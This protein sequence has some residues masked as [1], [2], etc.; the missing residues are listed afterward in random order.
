[1]YNR[2]PRTH[3]HAERVRD[4]ALTLARA[5]GMKDSRV[6]DAIAGSALVHDVGKLGIADDIL[7]KPAPLT[8]DEYEQVKRHVVIGS[9]LLSAAL[10]P[11]EL[12]LIVRHHHERWDGTGYPNRLPGEA[13]PIGARIVT[14]AD[15]FDA[16][17]SWRPY[18]SAYTRDAAVAWVTQRRGTAFDPTV[19]DA[20]MRTLHTIADVTPIS[21]RAHM[22]LV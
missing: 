17:T 14:V 21:R 10:L 9:D 11:R 19:V 22:Q 6:L 8:P 13:I 15:C 12:S 20:F 5:L 4:H 18:R 2:D 16:L 1:M 3:A 7:N